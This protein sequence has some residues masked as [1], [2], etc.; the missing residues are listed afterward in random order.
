MF[1]IPTIQIQKNIFYLG[2]ANN[3]RWVLNCV[4]TLCG[5]IDEMLKWTCDK[6]RAYIENIYMLGRK[7]KSCGMGLGVFLGDWGIKN[8]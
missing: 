7:N 3:F 4:A 1:Q 2:V 6:S 8:D 5:E